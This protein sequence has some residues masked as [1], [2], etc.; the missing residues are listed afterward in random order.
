[1]VGPR[2]GES[3][4]ELS[5]AVRHGLKASD[6]A[7]IHAYPTYSDGVWLAG[8]A[9]LQAG[10]ATPLTRRVLRLLLRLR[11]VRAPA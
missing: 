10:L 1:M 9:E 2:A 6:L 5:L 7:G 11:R 3:L 4:A 8:V